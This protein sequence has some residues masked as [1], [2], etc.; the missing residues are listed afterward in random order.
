MNLTYNSFWKTMTEFNFMCDV[1]AM[2]LLKL[3]I[4]K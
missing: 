2:E 1:A 4:G 3:D